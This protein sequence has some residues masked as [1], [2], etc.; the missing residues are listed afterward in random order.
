MDAWLCAIQSNFT[1]GDCFGFPLPLLQLQACSA[2]ILFIAR[3]AERSDS[4]VLTL[5][6]LPTKTLCSCR[7]LLGLY[8][9][10]VDDYSSLKDKINARLVDS[11]FLLLSMKYNKL[12]YRAFIKRASINVGM[13]SVAIGQEMILF[14]LL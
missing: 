3:P 2:S 14:C 1:L 11:F 10:T 9:E 5:T 7:C 6:R 12:V 8:Y 4:T 13:Q